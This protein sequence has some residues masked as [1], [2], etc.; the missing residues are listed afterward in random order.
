MVRPMTRS[1][2]IDVVSFSDRSAVTLKRRVVTLSTVTF[3]DTAT[4]LARQRRPAEANP[5]QGVKL[6]TCFAA[7]FA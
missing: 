3:P 6:L 2:I 4:A 1:D 7:N 5:P